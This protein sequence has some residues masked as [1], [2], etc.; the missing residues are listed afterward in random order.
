LSTAEYA[1]I[2]AYL[3]G[4]EAK[5]LTT[6]Q[7][8]RLPKT[9]TVSDVLETIKDTD[10]G[11]HLMGLSLKTFDDVDTYLWEYFG[12]CLE[13]LEW[14]KLMP[15]DMHHVLS[16]YRVKYDVLNTKTALQAISSGRRANLIPA[17]FIHTRG[18]LDELA[19]AANVDDVRK[20]LIEC[21]LWAYAT[22]LREYGE[23]D[24]KAK[25]LV[26]A[27]LDGEYYQSL[28]DLTKGV[29]DGFL[30]GKAFSI[31]MDLANLQLVSRA[32]IE[33]ITAQASEL[34]LGGGYMISD[35]MARDMLSRK[36][37]DLPGMLGGTQYREVADNI[38]AS[39]DRTKSVTVVEEVITKH[40]F[41]WLRELLSPRVMAP[42]MIIWYLITK[43][44]EV[45][46]LR[47]IFKA[48]FDNIPVEEIKEYLVLSS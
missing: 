24:T 28:L 39:Y 8:G 17:G 10:V 47:L 35:Q 42:M 3:K 1:F 44:L 30:L 13:S 26:E 31:I 5:T 21:D 41:R 32:I 25:L 37:A 19:R 22:V 2:S 27:K 45:K 18:L 33:G 48:A 38:A 20:V 43:E 7:V 14:L 23:G 16:I 9:A 15:A 4:A 6:D 36:L 34:L 46:N 29:E 40:K 11:K 12:Q